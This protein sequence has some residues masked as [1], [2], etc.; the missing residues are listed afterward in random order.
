MTPTNKLRFVER[1]VPAPEHGEGI[2]RPARILQQWH[3]ESQIDIGFGELE[4]GKGQWL[5]VPVE[6][7]NNNG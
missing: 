3:V 2:G 4:L 6:K 1:I 7:E 5:D